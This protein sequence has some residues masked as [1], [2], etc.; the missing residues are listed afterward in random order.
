MRLRLVLY[1]FS[2]NAW[3]FYATAAEA[4]FEAICLG[5]L[6]VSWANGSRTRFV[7][8]GLIVNRSLLSLFLIR[9]ACV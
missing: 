4:F 8:C 2:A 7:T 5:L 6:S 9:Y 1:A 3:A